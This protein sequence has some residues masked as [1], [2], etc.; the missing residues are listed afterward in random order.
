[1]FRKFFLRPELPLFIL[2]SIFLLPMC[3]MIFQCGCSYLWAGRDLHCNI[4]HPAPPH[5]PWCIAPFHNQALSSLIQMI[6]FVVIFACSLMSVHFSRLKM[7]RSYGTQLLAGIIG[8]LI[9]M[10]ALAWVYGKIY[11]YPFLLSKEFSYIYDA[12]DVVD[13]T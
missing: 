3:G 1:M 13:S 5:C 2:L 11:H 8:G 10:F 7:R 6:P 12:G 9:A 4:H